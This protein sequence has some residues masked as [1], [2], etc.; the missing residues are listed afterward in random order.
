VDHRYHRGENLYDRHWGD[1]SAPH[2]TLGPLTEPPFYGVRILAGDLGT[3]G[4]LTTDPTGR[5]L[6][7]YGKA[8]PGLYAVGNNSASV[9]GPGYAGSGATLG[10]CI[11]FGYLTGTSCATKSA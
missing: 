11:T 9:M 6:D 10:P 2:P 3:K 7:G 4:G 5:V 8:I 1:P